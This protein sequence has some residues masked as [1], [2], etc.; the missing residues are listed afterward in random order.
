MA[1]LK[2][3]RTVVY[4]SMGGD[5]QPQFQ[6]TVFTRH[7]VFGDSVQDAVSAPRWLLGR[8]WGSASETLKLESR[9]APEVFEQL[10]ARGHAIESL[11]DFDDS[12]GHAGLI[13]R[14]PDGRAE[15]AADP[16]SDGSVAY[17]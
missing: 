14:Y 10:A 7:L 12:A 1:Q 11:S 17:A 3:G 6:A 2:D 9:F 16:R 4:G 5:G 13:V 15:G 8:T